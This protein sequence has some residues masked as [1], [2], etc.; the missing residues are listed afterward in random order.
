ALERVDS[1][2]IADRRLI[3]VRGEQ[4]QRFP[5]RTVLAVLIRCGNEPSFGIDIED[6]LGNTQTT[7]AD[8]L[9]PRQRLFGRLDDV[10]LPHLP[11]FRTYRAA[12]VELARLRGKVRRLYDR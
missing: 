6:A 5:E 12:V 8:L 9:M 7:G 10:Q 4:R 1:H 2:F 3:A 11:V